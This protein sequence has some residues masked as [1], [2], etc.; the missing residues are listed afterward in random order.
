MPCYTVAT[1]HMWLL[2]FER[3]LVLL[4]NRIFFLYYFS[5]INL[6]FKSPSEASVHYIGLEVLEYLLQP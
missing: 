3:Y 6:C 4:R 1:V 5:L 2:T